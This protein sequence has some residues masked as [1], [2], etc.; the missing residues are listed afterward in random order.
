MLP[1]VAAGKGT[2][3]PGSHHTG[4]GNP[5]Y[6]VAIVPGSALPQARRI[7][8]RRTYRSIA[9]HRA[10]GK[11]VVCGRR[12]ARRPTWVTHWLR[13]RVALC[14][15][16]G[17]R[18]KLTYP[19]AALRAGAAPVGD[20]TRR[21]ISRCTFALRM[22]PGASRKGA[23]ASIAL[24]GRRRATWDGLGG[25]AD[26]APCA[27]PDAGARHGQSPCH[28]WPGRIVTERGPVAVSERT[29]N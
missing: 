14:A 21:G 8:S 7:A 16:R 23:V 13:A 24:D 6:M 29:S 22:A 15:D 20:G 9:G 3:G 4:G 28:A 10:G 25:G 18:G 2:S 27:V 17:C 5:T 1:N 12:V 19:R 11:A 26:G